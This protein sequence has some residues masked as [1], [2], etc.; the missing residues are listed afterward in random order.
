MSLN[1]PLIYESLSRVCAD[2]TGVDVV[3]GVN[4]GTAQSPI[5]R[6]LSEDPPTSVAIILVPGAWSVISGSG[7]GRFTLNPL[8]TIFHPRQPGGLGEAAVTLMTIFGQLYDAFAA[9]SKAYGTDP[10]LQVV[11]FTSGDGLSEAE[12][13]IDSDTWHLTWPFELEV[14]VNVPTTFQA[15]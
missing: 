11:N 2:V 3:H 7:M 4:I 13:P 15:Q 9:R 8:G 10:T 1:L 12:W 6:P 5:V 14:K